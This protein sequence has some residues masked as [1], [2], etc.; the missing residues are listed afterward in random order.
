[1]PRLFVERSIDIKAPASTVWAVLTRPEF[2]KEWSGPFGASGPIDS[3]W[4]PGSP[5]LWRNAEGRVYVSGHVIALEPNRRLQF[6][7]RSAQADKQPISG[8]EQDD[9]T[10][11]YSLS[12]DETHTSLSI[13]HGDF[14][15]VPN[16]EDVVPVASAVWERALPTIKQLAESAR[17]PMTNAREMA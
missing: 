5:V 3:D 7:V 4:K 11:T 13:A 15:N 9:I 17:D 10:Q 1:M 12:G 16:G 14:R 6:S 8:M 2:T